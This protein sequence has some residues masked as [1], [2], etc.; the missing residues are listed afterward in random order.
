MFTFMITLINCQHDLFYQKIFPKTDDSAV[1][2]SL[3]ESGVTVPGARLV[4]NENYA[5]PKYKTVIL[6]Q[7][8]KR[9]IGR[10]GSTLRGAS[11]KVHRCHNSYIY[12]LAPMR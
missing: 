3:S 5:P 10:S 11:V 2:T 1:E 6:S 9:T 4:S 7:L 12:L 8:C